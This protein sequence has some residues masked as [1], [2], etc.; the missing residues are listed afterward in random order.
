M[1]ISRFPDVPT[2]CKTSNY[3]N[4]SQ[5][6]VVLENQELFRIRIINMN[7]DRSPVAILTTLK[8][9]NKSMMDRTGTSYTMIDWPIVG[10]PAMSKRHEILSNRRPERCCLIMNSPIILDRDWQV[11]TEIKG[12][13]REHLWIIISNITTDRVTRGVIEF[14]RR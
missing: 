11:V 14:V 12:L 4:A 7:K 1:S 5:S 3:S 2:Q 13:R 8:T 9:E 10:H 6:I